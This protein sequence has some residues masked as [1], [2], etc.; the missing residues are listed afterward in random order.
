M[1]GSLVC[2]RKTVVFV[3]CHAEAVQEQKIIN[4]KY[5]TGIAGVVSMDFMSGVFPSKSLGST[6]MS[7]FMK[8]VLNNRAF[9]FLYLYYIYYYL[10]FVCNPYGSSL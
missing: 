9:F 1:L 5:A 8:T 6:Y 4:G 10:Y 2:F 7:G 3:R